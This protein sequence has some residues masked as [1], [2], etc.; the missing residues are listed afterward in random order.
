MQVQTTRITKLCH[1]KDIVTI[2]GMLP[3][4]VLYAREGDHVVVKVTNETPHNATIHWHGVRQMLSCWADGPA[5]ITQCPIQAG[6]AYTYRFTLA[7]QRGTLLWHAHVSWLRATVYGAIV[8]YPKPGVPYPFPHPYE[9]HIII[10]GDYWNKDAVQLERQI[11]D[12][13]GAAPPADAFTINGHPGPFYNCS[14]ND[15]YQLRVVPGK[16]YL[17]RIINAAL[18]M[19]NFFTIAGHKMTV[20]EADADYTKP[21]TVDRVMLAPGQTMNALVHADQP[22]GRYHMAM[23]PYQS[24]RNVAFQSIPA[25][26]YLQYAGR[27]GGH[28]D[29]AAPL[30]IRPAQLPKFNDN[31]LVK[32][33]TDALRSLQAT[34]L[35]LEINRNLFFTIGLN[36]E[37][38]LRPAPNQNCQGTN[39]SVFA[40]SMNN[41]SFVQPS[42]S[43]LQAYYDRIRGRVFTDD[44]PGVPLRVYDFVNGAPNRA[45]VDTQ[46]VNDTKV[47]VLEY[48][49]R[50]Q[51]VLQDTGTIT[52]ENHPM[53]L[54]GYSFYV[55]GNGKG[56]FNPRTARLNLVD[57]PYVNTIAVPVGGW[58]AIRFVA[59]NPGAWFMHCHLDIHLSWGLSM[60]FI[61]KDGKGP[62]ET[63]PPP[64]ADLP[65][66]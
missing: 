54:H 56:N 3:G 9:E 29:A 28:F 7:D 60:V 44:F 40:A 31:L 66:C 41:V 30:L 64:P 26:A 65:R 25:V 58:S 61:V 55:V 59:D 15:V 43:V 27:A 6:Q 10:L 48:G 19:E 18:N 62:S 8:I 24:A 36:A 39:T 17:F 34:H 20:V 57:P 32:R 47:F 23:G 14:T 5:Y 21:F 51:L 53:H 38:C 46:S 12:S 1:T 11:L 13:G 37:A 16:T 63:L 35:P 33:N 52:T 4:P 2:N 42:I 49:D 22:T 50:V 45:P